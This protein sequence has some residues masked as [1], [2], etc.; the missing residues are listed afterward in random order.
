MSLRVFLRFL[1]IRKK[2]FTIMLTL[3][4]LFLYKPLLPLPRTDR[5]SGQNFTDVWPENKKRIDHY[6]GD[7][8]SHGRAHVGRNPSAGWD[9]PENQP[10]DRPENQRW[11]QCRRV[12][13]MSETRFFWEW[14]VDQRRCRK[15]QRSVVDLQEDLRQLMKLRGRRARLVFLGDSRIRILYESLE[16]R[17]NLK[18]HN[19]SSL[20]IVYS[21]IYHRK[22]ELQRSVP[23]HESLPELPAGCVEANVV[24]LK[25][26]RVFCSRMATSDTLDIEFLWRPY[27]EDRFRRTLDR[28]ISDCETD[29]CPDIVAIDSG[30]WY[31]KIP[32][33]YPGDLAVARTLRFI[34]EL[35]ALEDRIRRLSSLTRV[36]WK[37][38]EQ[39][40]PEVAWER[41]MDVTGRMMVLSSV[42]YESAMRVPQLT[43]W[44]S[45]VVDSMQFYHEV[46][47]PHRQTLRA[48]EQDPVR[49]ECLDPMH[50]GN[51]VRWKWAQSLFN[52]LFLNTATPASDHCCGV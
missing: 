27:L 39:F 22:E 35:A 33:L 16:E 50:V 19:S 41:K 11:R 44:S 46:C 15:T 1:T 45:G 9:R 32:P 10:E 40:M 12:L 38:D 20:P 51:T 28:L 49:Y 30:A 34:E 7:D 21:E 25:P 48:S 23:S 17:L 6:F 31:A 36:I 18:P 5:P 4:V 13:R 26:L 42:M 29:T 47:R 3:A 52:V 24:R 2:P 43:V 37:L 8:W 14:D